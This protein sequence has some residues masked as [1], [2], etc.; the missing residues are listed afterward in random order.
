MAIST[1]FIIASCEGAVA[2]P[3]DASAQEGSSSLSS[4]VGD[5]ELIYQ[6]YIQPFT[7]EIGSSSWNTAQ[8]AA[9]D[10]LV[11]FYFYLAAIGEVAISPNYPKDKEYGNPLIPAS[12]LET[13]VQKYFDVTSEHIRK[14]EYY[15]AVQNSYWTGGIGST[16]ELTVTGTSQEGNLLTID[17]SGSIISID[18]R[19]NWTGTVVVQLLTD[20]SY[21]YISY[22]RNEAS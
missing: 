4:S 3:L 14:S 1:L 10:G 16:A 2:S 8:E 15:D 20:G 19:E 9:P 11:I 13:T 5:P 6:K 22:Q 17:Y 12:I 21:K 18:H 7:Y